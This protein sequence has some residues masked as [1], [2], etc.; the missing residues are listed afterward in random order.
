VAGQEPHVRIKFH[1]RGLCHFLIGYN[2]LMAAVSPPTEI[3]PRNSE[4]SSDT[5]NIFFSAVC[6]EIR[7]VYVNYIS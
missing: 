4:N 3:L 6:N 5:E 1:M 2:F 7:V